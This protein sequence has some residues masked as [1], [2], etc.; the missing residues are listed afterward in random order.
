[1]HCLG[2]VHAT[3]GSTMRNLGAWS[4]EKFGNV[5]KEIAKSRTQ[6]GE[7][8]LM[9]TDH[10]EIRKVTDRMNELPY[11][12]EMMWLQRSRVNWLKEGDR[13]T[14]FFHAKAIWRARKNRIQK[15]EDTHGTV[16]RD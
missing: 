8:M 15:L 1:M 16:H 4:R 6:L 13:N 5:S 9:N 12:E 11:R 3:L 10:C 7:L 14:Q 2:Y